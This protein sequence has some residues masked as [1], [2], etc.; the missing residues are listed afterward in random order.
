RNSK[1]WQRDR[2]VSGTFCSS[3]VAMIKTTEG[4][5]SS[6][7]F[8]RALNAAL[9]SWCTSSMM[10]IRYRS[11]HGAPGALL[12]IEVRTV[13]TPVF[14]A[15]SISSTST[16]VEVA[17]S[18]QEAHSPQGS[19]VGPFMQLRALATIRAVVVLPTPRA[20]AKR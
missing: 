7:V 11:R 1:T 12:M 14:E 9:E 2:M 15:A 10:K 17:I 5:G 18:R 4:G 19:T 3:V 8:K 20:P 13:S 6:I 16:D